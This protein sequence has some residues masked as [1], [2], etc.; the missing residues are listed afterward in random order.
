MQEQGVTVHNKIEHSKGHKEKVEVCVCVCVQAD[1]S[2]ATITH[3][4]G[5]RVKSLKEGKENVCRKEK[6]GQQVTKENLTED[7]KGQKEKTEKE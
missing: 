6:K 7:N 3:T 2:I 5:K 4:G 1:Q